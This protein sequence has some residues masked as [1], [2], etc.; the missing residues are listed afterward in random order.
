IQAPAAQNNLNPLLLRQAGAS[1]TFANRVPNA[2]LFLSDLNCHCVDPN[3]EF[4]LN[5][6]AWVDPAPG[7]FGTG[8]AYYND[9]RQQRQPQENFAIGRDFKVAREGK[10]KFNI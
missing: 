8:A 1:L 3:K 9:Y 7:Q 6:D 2:P 4:V 5:K 10:A